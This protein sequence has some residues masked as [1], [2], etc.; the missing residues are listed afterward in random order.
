MMG[1][2]FILE[3]TARGRVLA[4]DEPLS[5]WGGVDPRSGDLPVLLALVVAL[6]PTP[7]AA[8]AA[9]DDA[10]VY[11]LRA[12]DTLYAIA[13]RFMA[14][15]GDAAV[16]ALRRVNRVADPRRMPVNTQLRIPRQ[17]L[18]YQPVTLRVAS[19]SG[20]VT[21]GGGR[22][23]V[24]R[25]LREGEVVETGNR[26]FVTFTAG[27]DGRVSL[28]S[29][30]RAR[31]DLAR[32]YVLGNLLD[33]DFGILAGR[34]EFSAPTL[35]AQERFRTRTPVAV[36]AVRG[37]EYRV[38]YAADM[39]QATAEVIE[40][41]VAVAAGPEETLTPRGFGVAAGASGVSQPEA[42]LA[43][44]ALAAPG[45]VQTGERMDFAL[46]PVAGATAYR[47][48]VARDAGFLDVLDETMADQPAAS[49]AGQDNG[50]YF[51]RSR[52][53]S[54]QHIEGLSETVSFRRKRLGAVASVADS[55]LGDG[56]LFGWSA[57]ASGP[58]S[59]FFAFQL[60]NLADPA[61]LLV[62]EVGLTA[63]S[64]V[65][66]DLPPGRYAWRVAGAQADEDGLLKVWGPTSELL[67]AD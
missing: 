4:C 20:P 33:V 13:D 50:R 41:S 34:G 15:P 22:A 2:R 18:R 11:H 16:V 24:G 32:R 35:R 61:T 64:L 54:A 21:I 36:T 53:I 65:V 39:A 28:P 1:S 48:Q 23:E 3:G 63:S 52:A 7:V 30:S 38:G 42:L 44:P 58:G 5:F 17:L 60:W 27:A 19:F 26:G 37:T 66:T 6:L 67:V 31:L 51:V 14:V 56:Y 46:E 9:D 8:Q 57:E 10:V 62:D 47:V 55:P 25:V 49:F 59:T 12:G 29:N 40:G 45:A 43:S